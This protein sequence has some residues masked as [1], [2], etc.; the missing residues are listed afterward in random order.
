MVRAEVTVSC[1]P[2]RRRL[3]NATRS[4]H[5]TGR[6]CEG[7]G[8]RGDRSEGLVSVPGSSRNG[9]TSVDA[10]AV[11][12]FVFSAMQQALREHHTQR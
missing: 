4:Y 6:F 11:I 8:L 10:Q 9:I 7:Y 5:A 3:S 12:G 1:F 2:H